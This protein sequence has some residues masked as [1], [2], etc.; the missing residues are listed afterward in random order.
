MMRL[1]SILAGFLQIIPPS[2]KEITQIFTVYF[3][4]TLVAVAL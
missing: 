4:V 3:S 2:D 1:I